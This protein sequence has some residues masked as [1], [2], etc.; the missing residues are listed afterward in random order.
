MKITDP[1]NIVPRG[2]L[3]QSSAAFHQAMVGGINAIHSCPAKLYELAPKGHVDATSETF[4]IFRSKTSLV[5]PSHSTFLVLRRYA[6]GVRNIRLFSQL[7]G[8]VLAD[9]KFE[10]LPSIIDQST[11]KRGGGLLSRGFTCST[12]SNK[13]RK[14]Y[15]LISLRLSKETECA[16][17]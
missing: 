8:S 4:Q 14:V 17:T 3:E 12:L 1:I 6:K 2:D 5:L 11:G 16:I 9:R 15:L 13:R 10:N 7:L